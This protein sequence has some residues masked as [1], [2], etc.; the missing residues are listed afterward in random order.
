MAL[1]NPRHAFRYQIKRLSQL[2]EGWLVRRVNKE[3]MGQILAL[4]WE[5]RSTRLRKAC[6]RY[7]K[8]SINEVKS[9]KEWKEIVGAPADFVADL[10]VDLVKGCGSD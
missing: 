4:A 10:M 9:A 1:S 8:G 5:R 7:L 3:S 2:T 6:A